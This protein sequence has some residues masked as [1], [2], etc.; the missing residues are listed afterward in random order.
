MLT[1][2]PTDVFLDILNQLKQDCRNP[3]DAKPIL[4]LSFTSRHLRNVIDSWAATAADVKHDLEIFSTLDADTPPQSALSVLC[5][6][7]G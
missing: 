7:I 6:R 3:H 5:R 4:R 1:T 2:I